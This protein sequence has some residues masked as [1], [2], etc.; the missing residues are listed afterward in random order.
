[1]TED[2]EKSGRQCGRERLH[3]GGHYPERKAEA[4]AMEE[5]GRSHL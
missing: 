1:M 4:T 5:T 2:G 3:E